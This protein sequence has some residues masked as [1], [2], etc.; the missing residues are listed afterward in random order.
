MHCPREL[1]RQQSWEWGAGFHPK[2]SIRSDV[3]AP[4]LVPLPL[5]KAPMRRSI[6]I[7]ALHCL[8]PSQ[9]V[10]SIL[11]WMSDRKKHQ[12]LVKQAKE[13]IGSYQSSRRKSWFL[14]GSL[15]AAPLP[16]AFVAF[17][18]SK[19]KPYIA[20][21]VKGIPKSIH[22]WGMSPGVSPPL[23]FFSHSPFSG[24]AAGSES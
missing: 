5:S 21:P 4:V 17:E 15:L 8:S 11:L 19:S 2:S 3:L 10:L 12:C 14:S 16:Q 7:E 9:V 23:L 24:G 18:P 22:N 6:P 13:S 1:G 20:R